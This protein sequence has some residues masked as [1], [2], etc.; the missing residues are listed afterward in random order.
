MD[1]YV[2]AL[3]D[4][5]GVSLN[6]PVSYYVLEPPISQHGVCPPEA[7]A[8]LEGDAVVTTWL[9]HKHELVHAVSRA[10]GNSPHFFE[11]GAAT[12]LGDTSLRRK[13]NHS[14]ADVR[15]RLDAHWTQGL[16]ARDYALA[17]HFA[18]YLVDTYGMDGYIAMLRE[19]SD[20]QSRSS[21]EGTFEQTIG[22]SLDEAIDDYEASWP[23]CHLEG[24]YSS[25]F[26]C[27]KPATR[28]EKDGFVEYD[29]DMSCADPEVLGPIEDPDYGWVI[30]REFVFEVG[31]LT[32]ID[33]ELKLPEGSPDGL[34]MI[35]K[36]CGT[37]CGEIEEGARVLN[38]Y[39]FKENIWAIA[40]PPVPGWRVL[41]E[42]GRWVVRLMKDAAE[43][44][45]VRLRFRD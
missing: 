30:W 45:P 27:A 22:V 18:A 8:C 5:Y 41:L 23:F 38:D 29:F 12:Y 39:N 20:T 32:S 44:G 9:P 31:E 40:D 13:T 14:V 19:S 33:I 24:I 2:G 28:I 21:F 34:T 11:E 17:A 1:Q 26:E 36:P 3:Q 37:H 15:E 16:D 35:L 43:P 6:A 42:P 7:V 4:L 10:H 25:F